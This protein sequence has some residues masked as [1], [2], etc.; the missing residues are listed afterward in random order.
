MLRWERDIYVNLLAK[1]LKEEKEK[2]A[3]K[4]AELQAQQRKMNRKK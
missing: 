2:N 3:L 1:F 4:A